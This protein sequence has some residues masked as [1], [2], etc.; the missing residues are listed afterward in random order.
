MNAP[1][2]PEPDSPEAPCEA[3]AQLVQA[4]DFDHPG[5]QSHLT[6]CPT[7]AATAHR[8]R[9]LQGALGQL[10]R[11][12]SPSQ[13]DG[14]VAAALA[15]RPVERLLGQ[16]D[17]VRAPQVLD[18]LVAEEVAAPQL[19]TI[20]RTIDGLPRLVAP[21]ELAQLG[22]GSQ[23]PGVL[24]PRTLA[25]R[26]VFGLLAAGALGLV[27]IRWDGAPERAHVLAQQVPVERPPLR[28]K[29]VA[30]VC[31]DRLDPLAQAFVTGLGG[32]VPLVPPSVPR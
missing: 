29:A 15:R 18:R 3:T 26:A 32:G 27:W 7:C 2:N 28:L 5:V 16:L 25:R 22:A 30:L 21:R 17:R 9:R 14:L 19:H 12:A 13:L 23:R 10:R 1:T 8:V 6:R 11:T 31:A 4:G 24:T 20:R